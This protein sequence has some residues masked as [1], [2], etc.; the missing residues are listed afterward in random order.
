MA[1]LW[2]LISPI[3]KNFQH[4]GKQHVSN[5]KFQFYLYMRKRRDIWIQYSSH[6][7]RLGTL[8]FELISEALGLKASH[9]IDMGC[10]EG[11]SVLG[12]YYPAC[13]EP[14]LTL[15]TTK[16]S[17]NDF[18]TILLQ[19]QIGGLQVLYQNHWVDV[20]PMPGS[21]VIN[22]GDLLQAMLYFASILYFH[23]SM[24]F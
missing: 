8:L 18:I 17:D 19:D 21:L 6:V 14:E 5:L 12:H 20:P 7:M 10:A 2:L 22:I 11:L 16:H 1:P 9:L 24:K 23:T 15:G 3:L 4:A 13:P